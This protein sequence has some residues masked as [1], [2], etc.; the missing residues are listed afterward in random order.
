[1]TQ[2]H[3]ARL[4][5]NDVDVPVSVA[6][7]LSGVPLDL[8]RPASLMR[9]ACF[10]ESTPSCRWTRAVYGHVSIKLVSRTGDRG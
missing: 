9:S 4:S 2:S 8:S 1:M 3:T 5:Q 6:T 10:W 7:A